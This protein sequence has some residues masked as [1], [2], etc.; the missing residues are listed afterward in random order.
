M[1]AR[2]ARLES[3][4]TG[5]VA[6]R[7]AALAEGWRMLQVLEED[8]STGA[9]RFDRPGEGLFAA[10]RRDALAGVLGLSLD[11][12]ASDPGTARLRRLYVAAAH[13]GRGVGRALVE[14]A[15]GAA[16][17]H[18]FRLLRVRSPAGA[19]G[20]YEACGFVPAVLRSA[21]H[22]RPL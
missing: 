9:L 7:D 21:T 14:E 16:A 5:F 13:R 18:G 11:P 10:W 17:E 2:I 15:T 6:L 19:R 22:V 8:W 12:Y 20:F 3:L 4:P 1:S